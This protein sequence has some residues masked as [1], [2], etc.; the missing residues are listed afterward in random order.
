[1]LSVQKFQHTST[2]MTKHLYI[3]GFCSNGYDFIWTNSNAL[4]KR[5]ILEHKEI[6]GATISKPS[7]QLM[8][9]APFLNKADTS[10]LGAPVRTKYLTSIYRFEFSPAD[11]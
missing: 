10:G 4:S 2:D 8:T 5:F 9:S 11:L 7:F 3:I 1:M 6:L